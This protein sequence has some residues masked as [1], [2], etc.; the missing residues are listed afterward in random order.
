MDNDILKTLTKELRDGFALLAGKIDQTNSR[1]DQTNS[2]IGETNSRLGETNTRLDQAIVRLDRTSLNV[3]LLRAE[4][5]QKLDGVGAY[6]K[7]INGHILDHAEKI[8]RL[9][10]RLSDFEK[11]KGN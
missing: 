1:I 11:G 9:D 6:L 3:D 10:K 8:A 5:N 2:R 7:S 4:V